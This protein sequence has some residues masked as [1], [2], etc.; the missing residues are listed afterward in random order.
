[1]CIALLISCVELFADNLL[2]KYSFNKSGLV[3]CV[4]RN[5]KYSRCL[6][7]LLAL[8]LF[9]YS[10]DCDDFRCNWSVSFLTRW[11]VLIKSTLQFTATL[12]GPRTAA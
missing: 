12:S 8:A 2:C 1:M 3:Q 9:S 10:S 7:A 11:V 4:A 5:A 6:E